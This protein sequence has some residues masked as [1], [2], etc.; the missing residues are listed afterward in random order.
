MISAYINLCAEQFWWKSEKLVDTA[1]WKV[2]KCA[3]REKFRMPA[4]RSAYD[5]NHKYDTYYDGFEGFV[6]GLLS[7]ER[8]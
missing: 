7:A 5:E 4:I 6:A 3:M 1:V 2:W 8:S